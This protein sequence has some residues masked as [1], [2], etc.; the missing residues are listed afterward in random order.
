[1]AL[2]VDHCRDAYAA[3]R[4]SRSRVQARRRSTPGSATWTRAAGNGYSSSSRRRAH[5]LVVTMAAA[6]RDGR[7]PAC[8]HRRRPGGGRAAC[9]RVPRAG[10]GGPR[11]RAHPLRPKR[12]AHRSARP[13]RQGSDRGRRRGP[14]TTRRPLAAR[15]PARRARPPRRRARRVRR[16]CAVVDVATARAS[17]I[18]DAVGDDDVDRVTAAA[19]SSPRRCAT[20]AG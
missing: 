13:C 8:G 2:V 20:R 1:M 17:R 15:R 11:G 12:S 5:A 4:R 7:V 6:A 14:P 3:L 16:R 18:V 10:A 9:A 19:R